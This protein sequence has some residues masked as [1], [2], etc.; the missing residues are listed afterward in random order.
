MALLVGEKMSMD[1]IWCGHK[2]GEG[3]SGLEDSEFSGRAIGEEGMLWLVVTNKRETFWAEN[4]WP[5]VNKK[6]KIEDFYGNLRIV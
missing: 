5:Q 4:K 1:S 6:N 3:L 2:E